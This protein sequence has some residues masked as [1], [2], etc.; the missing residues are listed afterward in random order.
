VSYHGNGMKTTSVLVL[1]V[2]LAAAPARAALPPDYTAWG[3]LL[4]KYY[5]PARGMRYKALKAQ[6]KQTLDELR[7]RL[8]TVDVQLLSRPDQLAY[9]I[10]LYNI[11][12]VGIV[13]DHYP[14]ESI[15]DLSTDPIIRLNIFKK[16]LVDT[17]RGKISLNDI[18]NDKIRDGFKDP[19]I[20]FAINCA[21]RSCPP[22][23]T[24]PY[25]GAHISDQLDDQ[26]RKFLNGPNGV[27]IEK[28]GGGIVIHTTKVMDWFADDFRKWGG[29]QIEFLIRYVTSDK[30]REIEAAG[31]Q[32]DLQ[33]D[34]Y[35]W[36]LN[37]A[38]G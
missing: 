19:R 9:W 32:I 29:G 36:K 5:D 12:V 33:L 11:S 23:R 6:D 3:A 1:L 13:V 30:R 18:E 26:A 15:R 17:K 38:S 27:R 22:I 8:A 24:E 37:D 21:A 31:N 16:D 2:L 14:V 34:D 7:R 20:H 35:D 10:N 25:V 28:K 4:A